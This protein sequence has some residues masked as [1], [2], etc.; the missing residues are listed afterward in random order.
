MNILNTPIYFNE[1]LTFRNWNSTQD[2][3]W[4]R[5]ILEVSA[6]NYL[7]RHSEMVHL[8]FSSNYLCDFLSK[9][10]SSMAEY[11]SSYLLTIPWIWSRHEE[12]DISLMSTSCTFIAL[13]FLRSDVVMFLQKPL[14]NTFSLKGRK[15]T[16]RVSQIPGSFDKKK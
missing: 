4:T 1:L 11:D 16:K 13:L 2:M 9:Q 10:R 6:K 7:R 8:S 14:L 5:I 15:N 12:P 3:C